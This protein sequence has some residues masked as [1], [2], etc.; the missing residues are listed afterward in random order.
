M[1]SVVSLVA[2]MFGRRVDEGVRDGGDWVAGAAA[3]A[4]VD[5]GVG[6]GEDEPKNGMLIKLLSILKSEFEKDEC[7]LRPT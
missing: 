1:P 5:D 4:V 3:G 2:A 6:G 7:K